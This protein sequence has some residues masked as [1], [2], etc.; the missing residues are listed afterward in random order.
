M[1]HGC[2][3]VITTTSKL[4]TSL[5]RNVF[6]GARRYARKVIPSCR[7]GH[8]TVEVVSGSVSQPTIYIID[9][10]RWSSGQAEPEIVSRMIH[11]AAN[12]DEAQEDARSFLRNVKFVSAQAVRILDSRG[13]QI[14]SWT[15]FVDTGLRS[16]IAL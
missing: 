13:V 2:G 7:H 14:C 12:L 10:I 4:M 11:H 3:L 15:L 6:A 16:M 9:F 5:R 8:R 1:L